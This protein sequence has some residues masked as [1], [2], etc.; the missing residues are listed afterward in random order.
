MAEKIEDLGTDVL[1]K[2]KNLGA[3]IS[4]IFFIVAII[5][6]VIP[7]MDPYADSIFLI[8]GFVS[9]FIGIIMFLVLGVNKINKELKRRQSDQKERKDSE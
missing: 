6:F 4:A 8:I 9:F 3:I 2:K 7:L 5:L 1:K